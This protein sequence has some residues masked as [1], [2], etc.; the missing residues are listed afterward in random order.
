MKKLISILLLCFMLTG[1]SALKIMSAPFTPTKSTV[2]QQVEKSQRVVR[3][4]GDIVL[5]VDGKV[6]SCTKGFYSK[7]K[8][9]SEKQ[10]KLTLREKIAQFIAKGAG[11]MVWLAVIAVVLTF[12]GF[13][14]VVSGFFNMLF[15]TGKVLK[16]VVRGIQKARKDKVDLN[17]ALEASMDE[18]TKIEIAKLKQRNNIK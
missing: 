3:C 2:P 18:A 10:R 13:G 17:V 8:G 1:C 15:G 9:Y 5:D 7:E 6:L 12:T 4:D 14:W 16:Q 11:Y